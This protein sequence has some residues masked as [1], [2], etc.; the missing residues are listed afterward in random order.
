MTDRDDKRTGELTDVALNALFAEAREETALPSGDLMAR[1]LADA[2]EVMA[3][4][5]AEEAARLS[6]MRPKQ[7]HPVM[8]AIIAALGGW[9][10]VAGLATAGV[11]GLAFGLGAPTTVTALAT[12]SYVSDS[13]LG[14]ETSAGGYEIDDLMP[15]FY[16]L[17]TEG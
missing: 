5:E 12:G 16:D 3:Q 10:A 8:E 15:S 1:V 9:R 4:R 13:A 11:A 7:R 14:I 17:V 6:A 2:E